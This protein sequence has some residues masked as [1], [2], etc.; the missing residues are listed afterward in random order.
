[1]TDQPSN[2][3]MRQLSRLS[4]QERQFHDAIVLDMVTTAFASAPF[5]RRLKSTKQRDS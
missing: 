5:K 3:N 1:M 4:S 2:L